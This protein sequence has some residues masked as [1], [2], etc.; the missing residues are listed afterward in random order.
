[1]TEIKVRIEKALY[2]L[3]KKHKVDIPKAIL[4]TIER[5]SRKELDKP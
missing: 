5:L 3:A 2:D 1:M 4:K